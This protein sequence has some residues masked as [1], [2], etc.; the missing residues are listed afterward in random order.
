MTGTAATKAGMLTTMASTIAIDGIGAA[1]LH[2][3]VE[4]AADAI[5]S[6]RETGK[7]GWHFD[8]ALLRIVTLIALALIA[9]TLVALAAVLELL[10]QTF[11]LGEG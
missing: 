4:T 7:F 5:H 6:R 3:E 8:F 9:F 2:V 1:L 11:V 10:L